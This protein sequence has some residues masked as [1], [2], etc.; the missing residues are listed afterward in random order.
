VILLDAIY[1]NKGGGKVLLDLLIVNILKKDLPVFFLLDKRLE[2]TYPEIK[3]NFLFLEPSLLK[4]HQFYKKNKTRFNSVLAFGNIPPTVKMECRVFTFFQNVL[5]LDVKFTFS[6]IKLFL[7]SWILRRIKYNTD[8]WV[9]Q[10][11]LV[12]EQIVNNFQLQRNNVFVCPIFNDEKKRFNRKNNVDFKAI[13]FLYV[14]TG[15][16]HKNHVRLI[17]AFSRFNKLMPSSTLTVTVGK[18]YEDLYNYISKSKSDGVQIL[19]KEF[20]NREELESEYLAADIF[21]FPSLSESFGL[22]LIE[23]ALFNLPIISSNMK[24]VEQVVEPSNVFDPYNED[25]IFQAMLGFE[26]YINKPSKIVVRNGLSDLL[27]LLK[28]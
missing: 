7:K 16:V 22:G 10:N 20:I 21:I 12:R 5:Y 15:E 9:V 8:Y 2:N 25:E 17:N 28:N 13:K 19:N 1:I 11:F 24:Y 4:R 6:N 18:E 23:A 14:S 27:Q 3:Y 26:D